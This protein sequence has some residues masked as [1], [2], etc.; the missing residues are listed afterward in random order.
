MIIQ[1][2]I[3]SDAKELLVLQK[4]AYLSEAQIYNDYTI[5]PLVQ[6]LE[7]LKKQIREQAVFKAL[8]DDAI[9]GSVRGYFNAGTCY[10]GKLF[11]HPNYQNQ[12]IGKK[13][14]EKVEDFFSTAI[15]YEVFTGSKSQKNIFLYEKWGFQLFRTE[16]VGL[17]LSMVFMEKYRIN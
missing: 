5:E 9:I 15:R 14:M 11:V 13:L 17:D 2:A 16:E 1:R 6:S 3:V 12:G 4:M 10:V 7:S 8:I